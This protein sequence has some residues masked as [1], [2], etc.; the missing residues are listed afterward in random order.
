MS[1]RKIL[2]TGSKA[3]SIESTI[4]CFSIGKSLT[5]YKSPA[6]ANVK[7]KEINFMHT[8]INL[9]LKFLILGVLTGGLWFFSGYGF[10]QTAPPPRIVVAQQPDSPLLI[11]STYVDSS[12]SLQPRY[13]YSITNVSDKPIRAYTIQESISLGPG[14]SIIS[15]TMSHSPAVKLFLKPNE[16]RQEEGGLGGTYKVPPVEVSLAVDFVEFADG[17]RWGDDTSKSADRLDGIR[18]GGKAAI[19]NYRKI[20]D[21]EGD[22]GF[23]R[24]MSNPNLIQPEGAPKSSIWD[25]GFKTG[26][27]MVKR[28][29]RAAKTKG[30]QDE[31]NRELDRPFDS[32]EGRQEP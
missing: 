18:E 28:R 14:P 31:V 1:D 17:K 23:E 21:N 27:N 4:A 25:E 5:P 32:T 30:G 19:K 24:A 6:P 3:E 11:V 16:S 29:L 26:V 7:P 12:N 2:L 8:L 15:S 10:S 20:L 13:G 22:D 9:P